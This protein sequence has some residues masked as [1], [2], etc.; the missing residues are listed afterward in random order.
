MKHRTYLKMFAA[1]A[2]LAGCLTTAHAAHSG[3]S[4]LFWEDFG[5]GPV[6][7]GVWRSWG[8]DPPN[9]HSE[10]IDFGGGDYALLQGN[11]ALNW[12]VGAETVMSFSRAN[13]LSCTFT[14]WGLDDSAALGLDFVHQYPGASGIHGPLHSSDNS[15]A[16]YADI[17]CGLDFWWN[18]TGH[19]EGNS[20]QT[21]P[22]LSPAFF[23]ASNRGDD[24]D[25]TTKAGGMTIEVALGDVMGCMM[26][27]T[28]NGGISWTEEW[29]TRGDATWRNKADDA[30][31]ATGSSAQVYVGFGPAQ[32]GV[33]F[34]DI[35]VQDDLNR[36]PVELSE[37]TLE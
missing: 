29:D 10:A 3:G 5:S 31:L 14:F 35:Y 16:I 17:E 19:S 23:A 13:N 24:G 2:L 18:G 27:W 12:S 25:M 4:E 21:G 6:D 33:V 36:I 8:H 22:A 9:F 28:K 26:R 32:G 20:V 11:S 37:F 30:D 1:L 34:D 7:S 15:A